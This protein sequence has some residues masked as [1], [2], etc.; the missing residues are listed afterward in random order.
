MIAVYLTVAAIWALAIVQFI[1]IEQ[2]RRRRRR[3][4]GLPEAPSA[5][6]AYWDEAHS[7]RIRTEARLGIRRPS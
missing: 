7:R 2:R 4:M 5:W 1:Q 6:A 3:E